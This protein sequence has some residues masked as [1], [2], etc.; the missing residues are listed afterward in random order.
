M[1]CKIWTVEHAAGVLPTLYGE[2]K[3]L[4]RATISVQV[5]IGSL[6]GTVI[7]SS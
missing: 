6:E 4:Q 1:A 5:F 3:E 7:R 2:V